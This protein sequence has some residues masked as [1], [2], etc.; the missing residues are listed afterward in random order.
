MRF[1]GLDLNLLVA[2]DILFQELNV[3]RAA[4]FR[5]VTNESLRLET[6][7]VRD[8]DDAVQEM[9]RRGWPASSSFTTIFWPGMIQKKTL[10]LMM[11][12]SMAPMSRKAARPAKSWQASQVAATV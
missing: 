7:V 11:V 1:K 6:I 9:T 12:A 10:A 4:A 2:L 5:H 3:T 8:G